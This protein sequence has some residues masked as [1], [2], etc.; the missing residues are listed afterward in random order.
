M[1]K[2]IIQFSS[3]KGP[4][5]CGL[6]VALALQEFIKD[7]EKKQFQHQ[8]IETVEDEQPGTFQSVIV[9]IEE[10]VPME[11]LQT[12]VGNILWICE[13][14][15]RKNHK[16]KNWFIGVSLHQKQ[17]RVE[18]K[19]S[20]IEFSAMKASG[21]GGQH[22]NKTMSAVR[23]VHRPTGTVVVVSESRSQHEN[24]R[25]AI[26]RLK[27][28]IEQQNTERKSSQRKNSWS[29]HQQLERGNPIRIYEGLKFHWKR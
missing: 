26:Q 7:C 3:G 16:R 25:L 19:E 13:S 1:N 6:A 20:D 10:T 11:F 18:L 24:R 21:P 29:D 2:L 14:P 9:E 17:D 27:S 22:V 23:A 5:E 4:A 12:W 28:T 15:F 8:V